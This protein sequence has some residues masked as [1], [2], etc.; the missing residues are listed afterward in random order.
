M[1]KL[2]QIY[3]SL[4]IR[5]QA[6]IAVSAILL[7]YLAIVYGMARLALIED[8]FNLGKAQKTADAITAEVNNN[9][10]SVA[11][12]QGEIKQIKKDEAQKEQEESGD[13]PVNFYNNRYKPNK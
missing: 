10:Q 2:K 6:A 1:D 7:I 8:K 12:E 11:S 3:S 13:D 4:S 9:N 5:A